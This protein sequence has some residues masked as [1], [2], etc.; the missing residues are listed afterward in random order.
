MFLLRTISSSRVTRSCP[1]RANRS[2][3]FNVDVEQP[4]RTFRR[5][6]RLEAGIVCVGHGPAITED[7]RGQLAQAENLGAR[8]PLSEVRPTPAGQAVNPA[9]CDPLGVAASSRR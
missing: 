2:G 6:A 8:P 1:S 3:A 4:E 9:P 5:L 7:A